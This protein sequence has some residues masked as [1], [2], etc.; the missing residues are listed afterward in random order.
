MFR[1]GPRGRQGCGSPSCRDIRCVSAG[2]NVTR[3]LGIATKS[4]AVRC[5]AMDRDAM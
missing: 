2:V 1:V 4:G 5:D 3:L